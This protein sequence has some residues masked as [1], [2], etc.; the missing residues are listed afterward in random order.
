MPRP[1]IVQVYNTRASLYLRLMVGSRSSRV[2]RFAVLRLASLPRF[3]KAVRELHTFHTTRGGLDRFARTF[4]TLRVLHAY[5]LS[6]EKNKKPFK[7][8]RL[9]CT[10]RRKYRKWTC[11]RT[12]FSFSY[13]LWRRYWTTVRPTPSSTVSWAT[14][15]ECRSCWKSVNAQ[16]ETISAFESVYDG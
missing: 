1:G 5:V 13:R 15:T 6:D 9:V 10:Y 7:S 3:V 16:N 12:A 2:N 4:R 8:S 11:P 14:G